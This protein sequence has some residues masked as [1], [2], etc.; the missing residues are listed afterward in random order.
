MIEAVYAGLRPLWVGLVVYLA[1]IVLLRVSGKR[2]MSKWNAFDMVVTIALG[3]V[4]ATTLISNDVGALQGMVALALLVG[5]QFVI[6]WSALRWSRLH[7]WTKSRPRLLLRNGCF[8]DDALRRERVTRGEVLAAI[9]GAGHGEVECIDAV[10]LET[11][12]SVSVIAQ[13]G[14]ATALE[15][16]EGTAEAAQSTRPLPER[17]GTA[18][19]R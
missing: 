11:D 9:R 12:G 15:D 18:A 3:S 4:L 5:L 13:A 1:L 14:A 2:T 8:D 19:G 10:V 17:R 16:V 6:T 7:H